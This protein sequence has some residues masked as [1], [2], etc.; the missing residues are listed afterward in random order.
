MILKSKASLAHC[1]R[2]DVFVDVQVMLTMVDVSFLMF[3]LT[4][5]SCSVGAVGAV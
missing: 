1:P 5:H 4:S 2:A 3:L